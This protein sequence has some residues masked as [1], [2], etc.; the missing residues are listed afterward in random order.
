MRTYLWPD[1]YVRVARCVRTHF[2][3]FKNA[4]MIFM[5]G[6]KDHPLIRP[7]NIQI[8][9]LLKMTGHPLILVSAVLLNS[10]QNLPSAFVSQEEVLR[11]K[12]G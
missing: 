4:G 10:L 8:I 3:V 11:M 12:G 6:Q 1:A 7:V 9:T 2:E 5:W